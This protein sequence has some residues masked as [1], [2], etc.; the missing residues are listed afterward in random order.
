M[1]WSHLVGVPPLVFGR[2]HEAVPT[3]CQSRSGSATQPRWRINASCGKKACCVSQHSVQGME[4]I[5]GDVE[6]AVGGE[7]ASSR[8]ATSCQ[9][10]SNGQEQTP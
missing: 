9:L 4:E 7:K 6:G 10:T 8:T 1:F 2:Y 5:P 3:T